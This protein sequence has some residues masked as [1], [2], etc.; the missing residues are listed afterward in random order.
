MHSQQVYLL[1][2]FCVSVHVL[3]FLFIFVVEIFARETAA[4]YVDSI[5][6]KREK[7]PRSEMAMRSSENNTKRKSSFRS[8]QT[9]QRV[10][11]SISNTSAYSNTFCMPFWKSGEE[12]LLN[13]FLFAQ[14]FYCDV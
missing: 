10:F 13:H 3:S 11:Y 14:E 1:E 2:Q 12:I 7:I 5:V 8:I 6:C 9:R 4:R